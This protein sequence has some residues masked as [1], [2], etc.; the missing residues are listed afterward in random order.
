MA[1]NLCFVPSLHLQQQLTELASMKEQLVNLVP[2]STNTPSH[3]IPTEEAPFEFRQQRLEIKR[4]EDNIARKHALITEQMK[5]EEKKSRRAGIS[6]LALLVDRQAILKAAIN[7]PAR[8]IRCS[9][10]ADDL[11]EDRLEAERLEPLIAAQRAL[12]EECHESS[13]LSSGD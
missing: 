13:S 7:S 4:L 5:E 1:S 10:D 12:L 8:I 3:S 11:W 9:N 6:D 2:P